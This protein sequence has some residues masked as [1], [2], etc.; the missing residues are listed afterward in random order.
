MFIC[1][2]LSR[3]HIY[4]ISYDICLSWSDLLH[5][6]WQPLGPT[7]LQ[8]YFFTNFPSCSFQVHD[9]PAKPM[10]WYIIARRAISPSRMHSQVH[11][12]RV[13]LRGGF[14]FT[15]SFKD[16]LQRGC[17]AAAVH[18]CA[19][20]CMCLGGSDSTQF[21]VGSSGHT[22]TIFRIW[23]N[24]HRM[25]SG[26]HGRHCETDLR[27][28]SIDHP[29]STSPCS[30][31]HSSV[32][33]AQNQYQFRASVQKSLK[34]LILLFFPVHSYPDNRLLVPLGRLG[35]RSQCTF[36]VVY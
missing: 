8:I 10:T 4:A 36:L 1:T 16:V 19:L 13:C 24:N 30:G 11:C 33:G 18:F 20:W 6:V 3:F 29:V 31:S 21:M 14:P 35:E 34:S 12:W 15:I 23:R 2:I 26:T 7:M 22:V 5:S 17:H 28:N 25:D 27:R 32:W 9:H